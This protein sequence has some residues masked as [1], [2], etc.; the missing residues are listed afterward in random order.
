MGIIEE[1]LAH[2]GLYLGVDHVVN[3]DRVGAARIVITPLPGQSGVTMDYEIFNP[4]TPTR[5]LGHV[6]RTIIGRSHEGPSVMVISDMHAASV[7]ILRETQP[8]VFEL[9]SEVAAYP[10][11]VLIS[12][13]EPDHLHH[14][15]WFGAPGEEAVERVVTDVYRRP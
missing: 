3:P 5:L 10:M 6:E 12:M 15:W 13:P 7:A 8:G 9:G 1:L 11:K 4:S 2:P 14:S